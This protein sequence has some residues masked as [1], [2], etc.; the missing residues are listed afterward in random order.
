MTPT[1]TLLDLV[2]AVADCAKSEAEVVA[3]VAH[4]VN[5]GRVRLGGNFCGAQI[6]L[7]PAGHFQS[8]ASA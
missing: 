4:L 5:S 6:D 3:T 2:A 8:R 1:V 7:R